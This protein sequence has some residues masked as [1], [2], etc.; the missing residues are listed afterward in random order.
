MP[1]GPLYNSGSVAIPINYLGAGTI[2]NFNVLENSKS[3][4]ADGVVLTASGSPPPGAALWTRLELINTDSGGSHAVGIPSSLTLNSTSPITSVTLPAS[5]RLTL[6]FKKTATDCYVYGDPPG[7]VD[8]TT[9]VT[10]VLPKANG[11]VPQGLDTADKPTFANVQQGAAS[12]TFASSM[13]VDFATE[14]VMKITATGNLT[15]TTANLA[16]GRSKQ[17]RIL[18]DATPRTLTLPGWKAFGAALPTTTVAN[19]VTRLTLASTGT[20]DAEVDA[21]SVQ[22][23]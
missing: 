19:K 8:L 5:G 21:V 3:V 23:V 12:P 4:S 10:G 1:L 6:S 9:D 7:A 2:F 22:E 11:G 17:V 14:A 15:L 16:A 20:T 18:S 13:V